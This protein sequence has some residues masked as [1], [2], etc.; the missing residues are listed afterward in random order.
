MTFAKFLFHIG[1]NI[2]YAISQNQYKNTYTWLK[3]Q[4]TEFTMFCFWS[5][6]AE[7]YFN[8]VIL[9]GYAKAKNFLFF[10]SNG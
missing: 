6:Y 8:N 7:R 9:F 5:E 4:L 3:K 1:I 2:W 10:T